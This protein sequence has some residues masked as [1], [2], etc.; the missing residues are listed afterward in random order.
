MELVSTYTQRWAPSNGGLSA[1]TTDTG[2]AAF[3]CGDMSID[4]TV[5]DAYASITVGQAFELMPSC[6]VY[7]ITVK[8]SKSAKTYSVE[9]VGNRYASIDDMREYSKANNDGFEKL[10]EKTI[11]QA[12]QKAEEVID[13]SCG[14]SFCERVLETY[15]YACNPCE[16]P[17]IDAYALDCPLPNARLVSYCQA[18]GITEPCTARITYG[19][20]LTAQISEACVRL[21]ASY[22]RPRVAAENARGTAM[23]GVFISYELATGEEGSWTG[24]PFVD[25][26]IAQNRSRRVL[27]G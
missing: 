26:A 10:P 27:L 18:I 24:I 4:A 14:R 16:L 15:L 13:R 11:D 3:I 7:Q 2:S 9:R 8:D 21:A 19:Q 5:A 25:A 20:T 22:L 17:V 23:D 12:I 6:G 1:R